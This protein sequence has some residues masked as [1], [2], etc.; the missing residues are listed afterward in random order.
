[1][2]EQNTI[3]QNYPMPNIL[4]LPT[5]N[6]QASCSY[7]F[8]PHQH[9][10]VMSEEVV[11]QTAKWIDQLARQ[12]RFYSPNQ[13]VN[14]IF[15]G[16]EP[17]LA[18][19]SFFAKALPIFTEN[20]GRPVA[21]SV[22]SNLWALDKRLVELFKQYKV[23]VAVSVD[24]PEEIND[25]QRGAG[26]FRR[27]MAGLQMLR[28]SDVP[29]FAMCTFTSLSAPKA[30][31][32][33]DFFL[34]QKLDFQFKNVVEPFE[35]NGRSINTLSCEEQH[36]LVD[37]LLRR[38]FQ[39]SGQIRVKSLERMVRSIVTRENSMYIVGN[40]LGKKLAVDPEGGIYLCQRFAG[41]KKYQW[42]S[43]SRQPSMEQLAGTAGYC[44]YTQW[45]ERVSEECA[46]CSYFDICGGGC[47][48]NA[49]ASQTRKGSESF[50]DPECGAYKG[51]L[52]NLVELI[53]KH[54][55]G[56]SEMDPDVSSQ[57]KILR[58][59]LQGI[60]VSALRAQGG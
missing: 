33:F 29:V 60:P 53:G 44:I 24:G 21:F 30:D 23:L 27:S 19:Y 10:A 37:T 7:C 12:A 25:R 54:M 52:D 26:Y 8:G 18:G 2:S 15:H 50:K 32:I 35:I 22:L 48:Y 39:A 46:G 20:I 34:E 56:N 49:F 4:L 55:A 1:M 57:R 45:M 5:L 47:A 13:R 41:M 6:C 40:C 9:S 51:I 58:L 11:H 59:M 42:A 14:I 38:F 36:K 17:L 43:V 16:G 3:G 31:E 28:D